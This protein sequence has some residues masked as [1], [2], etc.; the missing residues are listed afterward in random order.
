MQNIE[1]SDIKKEIEIESKKVMMSL[2]K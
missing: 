2:K 1:N